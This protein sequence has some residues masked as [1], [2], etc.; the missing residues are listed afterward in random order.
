MAKRYLSFVYFLLLI[1]PLVPAQAPA[2]V[3]AGK[4][5]GV[6]SFGLLEAFGEFPRSG[7]LQFSLSLDLPAAASPYGPNGVFP[8][9]VEGTASV[10]QACSSSGTGGVFEFGGTEEGWAFPVATPG[11]DPLGVLSLDIFDAVPAAAVPV[12]WG[13]SL[14]DG[15]SGTRS[16]CDGSIVAHEGLWVFWV[17]L[18]QNQFF[19]QGR[20]QF[21]VGDFMTCGL[22]PD[23]TGTWS[24]STDVGSCEWYAVFS[25][26]QL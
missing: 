1:G 23:F 16:L 10:D 24:T 4:W 15:S 7:Q 20:Q 17:R 8:N 25:D 2:D 12:V 19:D 22:A 9:A 13:A 3:A 14:K 18:K 21:Q 6:L 11:N 26:K 5:Q